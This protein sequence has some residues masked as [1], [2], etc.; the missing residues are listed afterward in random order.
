MSQALVHKPMDMPV[1][2]GNLDHYMAAVSQ[3]PVLEAEA[4][5]RLARALRERQD[6]D[7]ARKLIA[8]SFPTARFEPE[9]TEVWTEAAE[10]FKGLFG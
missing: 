4:E 6:L 10:R 7:A 5:E 9:S 1:P 3:Y 2:L 8:D